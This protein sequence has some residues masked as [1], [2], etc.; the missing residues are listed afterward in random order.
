MSSLTPILALSP[1][2]VSNVTLHEYY[3]FTSLRL[4]DVFLKS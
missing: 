2:H 4:E 3:M 1:L